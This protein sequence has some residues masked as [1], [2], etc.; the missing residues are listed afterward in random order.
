M[1][2][3]LPTKCVVVIA[4]V[5]ASVVICKLAQLMATGLEYLRWR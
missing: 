1:K 4:A 2:V 3:D 5:M